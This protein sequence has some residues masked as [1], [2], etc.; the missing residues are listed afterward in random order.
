MCEMLRLP[1]CNR[2]PERAPH[3]CNRTFILC[4]RCTYVADQLTD[5]RVHGI[6]NRGDAAEISTY[7]QNAVTNEMSGNMIDVCPVGAL[8]DKTFRFKIRV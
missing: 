7:I 1:L 5:N 6:M 8:T 4:Y 3:I 2:K